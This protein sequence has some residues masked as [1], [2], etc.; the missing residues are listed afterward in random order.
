MGRSIPSGAAISL[1]CREFNVNE[2]WLRTGEGE[3]FNPTS[4]NLKITAFIGSVLDGEEITFKQRLIGV[5]SR[6][7]ETEWKLLEQK[8]LE[9]IGKQ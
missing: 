3:M 9:I 8:F 4:H 6:L 7:D 2:L 1:I 5:L